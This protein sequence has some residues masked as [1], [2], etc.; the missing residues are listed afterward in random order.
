MASYLTRIKEI[1]IGTASGT[2]YSW[3]GVKSVEWNDKDPYIFLEVPGGVG[4]YQQIGCQQVTG[5]LVCKD[6]DSLYTALYA[7]NV[8]GTD[9][10]IESSGGIR[11]TILFF[12]VIAMDHLGITKK[13]DFTNVRIR[14]VGLS[15]LE[16][17]KEVVSV[18]SFYADQVESI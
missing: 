11:H 18:V 10:A 3:T 6:I 5:K 17:D 12:M 9:K 4:L 8:N 13:Y 14:T 7:T 15:G 16:E 2:Y 1:R